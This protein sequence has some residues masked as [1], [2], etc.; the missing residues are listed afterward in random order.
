[1]NGYIIAIVTISIV[2]GIVSSLVSTKDVRLKKCISFL[3]SLIFL[4]VLFAPIKDAI[5]KANDF[6]NSIDSFIS[7]ISSNVDYSN[8]L[9]INS[10]IDKISSGIK[11]T[12]IDE[13]NLKINDVEIKIEVDNTN[14]EAVRIE[15]IKI[16]LYNEATWLDENKIKKFVEDLAGCNVVI[17]KV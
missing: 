6:K 16:Y 11:N 7:S 4:I 13:F 1:M 9:I 12:I 10:S 14:I 5:S 2:G 15:K 3:I 17:K 8:N